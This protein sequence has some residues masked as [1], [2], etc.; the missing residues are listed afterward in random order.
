[1]SLSIKLKY[2]SF[3][4]DVVNPLFKDF[5]LELLYNK[6]ILLQ[7]EN[8]TGKSTLAALA[9]GLLHPSEGKII[10]TTQNHHY[11]RKKEIYS[12]LSFLRQKAEHNILAAT[13]L[14]DLKLWLLSSSG[15]V[16]KNDLRI[17]K[18]LSDWDLTSKK[19][20]P[21]WELSAGE[22]KSLA[23]AGISLY[24]SRY[25]I[26][27]EPLAELDE[28][29]K[30]KLLEILKAKR[31]GSPGM[32]IITQQ[33]DLLESLADAVLTLLPDGEIRSQS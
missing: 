32:L 6:T 19:E 1:M 13:P 25:W 23:L 11:L 26:L 31:S 22:L 5:F 3:N 28:K 16:H 15:R 7:G 18:T 20:T 12:E 29:H 24:K 2:I 21:V 8:G 27:D 30:V 4:Y 17:V 33:K 14:E 10:Y 9:A